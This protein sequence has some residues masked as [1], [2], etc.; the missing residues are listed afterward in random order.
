[1]NDFLKDL[2]KSVAE[3]ENASGFESVVILD[4]IERKYNEHIEYLRKND[5]D[6]NSLLSELALCQYQ[7]KECTKELDKLKEKYET[8]NKLEWE[9]SFMLGNEIFISKNTFLYCVIRENDSIGY[10]L[11]AVDKR[12]SNTHIVNYATVD[13]CKDKA[14]RIYKESVIQNI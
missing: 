14:E 2:I 7:L 12:D 3:L 5:F 10:K 8:V 13:D 9:Q 4:D 6:R 11:T 1:M